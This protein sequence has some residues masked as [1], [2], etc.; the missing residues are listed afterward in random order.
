MPTARAVFWIATVGAFAL[1][2]R[3][4][5]LGPIPA[6]VPLFALSFYVTFLLLGVVFP[7][8]GMFADV[9]EGAQPGRK[10][11]ALPFD[12]GPSQARTPRVLEILAE[13]GA[14][15]TFFVRG[16]KA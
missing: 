4:F 14:K 1:I 16:R 5:W 10:V 7:R 2:V 11:V 8:W 13:H 3:V 15:A 9:I 12:E 6:I